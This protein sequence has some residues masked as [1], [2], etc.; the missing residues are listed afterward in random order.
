MFVVNRIETKSLSDM[1]RNLLKA[2][3]QLLDVRLRAAHEGR[4]G[5][6][7]QEAKAIEKICLARDE[8]LSE[9]SKRSAKEPAVRSRGGVMTP[10]EHLQKDF[11]AALSDIGRNSGMF[12]GFAARTFTRFIT[13]SHCPSPLE[14]ET[15][16]LRAYPLDPDAASPDV[17]RPE[18]ES[19]NTGYVNGINLS[20][21]RREQEG[22]SEL[23]GFVE[24]QNNDPHNS[25]INGIIVHMIRDYDLPARP[26]DVT[27]EVSTTPGISGE[28]S[29]ISNNFHGWRSWRGLWGGQMLLRQD[30]VQ[31]PNV[32]LDLPENSWPLFDSADWR[33]DDRRVNELASAPFALTTPVIRPSDG[34]RVIAIQYSCMFLVDMCRLDIDLRFMASLGATFTGIPSGNLRCVIRRA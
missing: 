9:L 11:R 17:D 29:A 19:A 22:V 27:Y 26:F 8:A 23:D 4:F 20:Y 10:A 18:P 13:P 2:R 3:A 28:H 21:R 1:S 24:D 6:K 16:F 14:E 31:D 33:V 25:D 30:R 34:R 5:S 32:E 7:F 12:R 15:V